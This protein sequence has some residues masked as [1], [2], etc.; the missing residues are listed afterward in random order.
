MKDD[1][2]V[3]RIKNKDVRGLEEL[4]RRYGNYVGSVIR[5]VILPSLSE[6]DAEELTAD[7]FTAV[8][9]RSER[10]TGENLK[11]YLAAAARNKAV[12]RLRTVREVLPLDEEIA[13]PDGSFE[14]ETDRRLLA[15]ALKSALEA[16]EPS[17][18]KILTDVYYYCRSVRE[19]AE[20]AGISE[21]AAKTRLFRARGRLKKI[22]TERG[23]VYEN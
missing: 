2:I 23:F 14:N 11:S 12:S 20:E 15:E 7:V 3:T 10:L 1:D 9:K 4:I 19:V 21:T 17:D 5:R 6:S 8:W 13:V 16:M 22:L 18:R